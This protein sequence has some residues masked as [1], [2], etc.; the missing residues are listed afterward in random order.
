MTQTDNKVRR[1]LSLT[2]EQSDALFFPGVGSKV[3]KA[4][5]FCGLCPLRDSCLMEA[6]VNDLQGF[7]AGTTWDER[8]GMKGFI[9]GLEVKPI[10]IEEFLPKTVEA[11]KGRRVVRRKYESS[12][13]PYQ[14]LDELDPLVEDLV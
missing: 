6:I 12:P 9:A 13:D 4:R 8:K 2:L 7:Y 5:I 10:D 11:S 14:Y 3:S 1:C